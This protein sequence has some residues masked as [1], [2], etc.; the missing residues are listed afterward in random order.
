MM[1]DVRI[2]TSSMK[3]GS[4]RAL[5]IYQ[6]QVIIEQMTSMC[7]SNKSFV[8]ELYKSLYR[9]GSDIYPPI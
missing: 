3:L 6:D 8:R 2:F 4:Q 7:S 9:I 1:V 5:S